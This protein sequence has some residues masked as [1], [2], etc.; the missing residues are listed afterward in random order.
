[1]MEGMSNHLESPDVKIRK[2][3]MILGEKLTQTLKLPVKDD[4]STLK[5]EYQVDE[6]AKQLLNSF[7]TTEKPGEAFYKKQ[8]DIF[9][10]ERSTTLSLFTTTVTTTENNSKLEYT[11]KKRNVRA[12]RR[13]KQH[14]FE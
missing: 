1:M 10:K 12:D 11:S 13:Q 2:L 8:K 7:E 4:T 5:F 14:P 9:E 6:D 3:A